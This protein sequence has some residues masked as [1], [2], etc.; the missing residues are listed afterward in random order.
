[1]LFLKY[2]QAIIKL[3]KILSDIIRNPPSDLNDYQEKLLDRRL[4]YLSYKDVDTSISH[5]IRLIKM[6]LNA[7]APPKKSTKK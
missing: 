4:I 1:L 5:Q 6:N 7:N 2:L 3:I